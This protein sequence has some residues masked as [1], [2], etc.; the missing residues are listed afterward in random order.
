MKYLLLARNY[1][2]TKF[3]MVFLKIESFR[4]R[5]YAYMFLKYC[6]LKF[7]VFMKFEIFIISPQSSVICTQIYG[8]FESFRGWIYVYFW[9]ILT[10]FF[11]MKFEIFINFLSIFWYNNFTR[12]S[13]YFKNS[14]FMFL[15]F[16]TKIFK[17]SYFQNFQ[18]Y[19]KKMRFLAQI[20][21]ANHEAMWSDVINCIKLYIKIYFGV[22][23]IQIW[24][25][26]FQWIFYR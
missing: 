16:K 8:E 9:K 10:W 19:L 15:I 3:M 2:Y 25:I 4:G 5:I 12:T 17:I 21:E 26:F 14:Y 24:T 20:W 18:I 11:F 13:I 23:V 7:V 22:F 6:E 1:L